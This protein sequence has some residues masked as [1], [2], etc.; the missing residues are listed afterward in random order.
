MRKTFR[1]LCDL[2]SFRSFCMWGGTNEK[3]RHTT[4]RI[5]QIAKEHPVLNGL[6]LFLYPLFN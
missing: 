2:Y 5:E 1:E 3:V 6:A 4:K